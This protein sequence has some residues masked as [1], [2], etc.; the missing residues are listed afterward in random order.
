LEFLAPAIEDV[1]PGVCWVSVSHVDSDARLAEQLSFL[2]ECG[3]KRGV[4]I[5]CS[6]QALNNELRHGIGDI[7]FLDELR[8]VEAFVLARD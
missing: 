8:D 4:E 2:A 1:R 3:R 7:T 5:L 6:G